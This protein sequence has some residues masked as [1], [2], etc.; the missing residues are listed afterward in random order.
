MSQMTGRT[1]GQCVINNSAKK[2][3]SKTEAKFWES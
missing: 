3:V 2:N 1:I